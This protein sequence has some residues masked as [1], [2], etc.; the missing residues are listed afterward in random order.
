MTPATRY[1]RGMI[2]AALRLVP[3]HVNV[4]RLQIVQHEDAQLGD[5]PLSAPVEL[6]AGEL[7]QHGEARRDDHHE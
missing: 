4:Y 6:S 5:A 2:D 7:Q 1:H 3:G